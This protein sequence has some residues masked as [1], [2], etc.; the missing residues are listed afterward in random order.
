MPYVKSLTRWYMSEGKK[1]ET[2]GELNYKLTM[3]ILDY[4]CNNDRNYKTFND[5][6]GVLA[7][8]QH[9]LYRR[10]IAPYEDEAIARNGDIMPDILVNK[11]GGK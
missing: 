7:C 9:E 1:P 10:L 2:P 11:D 3:I 6:M 8:I 5:V 4:L